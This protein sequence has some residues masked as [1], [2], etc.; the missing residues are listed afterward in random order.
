MSAQPETSIQY[1]PEGAEDNT[2]EGNQYEDTPNTS[3]T[4]KGEWIEK[5]KI[6]YHGY[7]WAIP[8]RELNRLYHAL[9]GNGSKGITKKM[10]TEG[11][12]TL[13]SSDTTAEA[14]VLWAIDFRA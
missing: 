8:I 1:Q 9:H 10:N 12:P 4:G 14:F 6:S 2:L 11:I 13:S 3:Q 5:Y 7:T